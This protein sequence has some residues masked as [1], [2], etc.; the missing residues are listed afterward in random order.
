MVTRPTT[1]A[2]SRNRSVSESVALLGGRSRDPAVQC[3]NQPREFGPVG[4]DV[5]GEL[6]LGGV[7]DVVAECLGEQLVGGGE[8]LLTVSE[9]H[10]GPG[11]EGR[12][13][14]LG[15]HGRLAQTRLARDQVDLTSP[16]CRHLFH[17]IGDRR[18]LGISA[19]HS[20]RRVHSQTSGK[21]NRLL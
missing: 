9:Q 6:F 1:A 19:H 11:V 17:G 3:G 12:P 20:D 13:C 10:A 14:R 2:K 5:G 4:L 21:R 16:T 8:I 18:H 7:G 15:H